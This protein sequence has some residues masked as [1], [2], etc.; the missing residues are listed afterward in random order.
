MRWLAMTG[1]V[2]H[3]FVGIHVVEL[4]GGET[5]Y[6]RGQDELFVPASRQQI[7]YDALAL[8][9]LGPVIPIRHAGGPREASG[10]WCWV[11]GNVHRCGR[12]YPVS[13]KGASTRPALAAI[14]LAGDG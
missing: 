8:T 4:A 14:G 5:V 13:K 12:V 10:D 3:G 6:R 7:I 1:P 2:S 9:R 11:G